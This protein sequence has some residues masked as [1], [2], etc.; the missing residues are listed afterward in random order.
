MVPTRAVRRS[1]LENRRARV[2]VKSGED[3][4][5]HENKPPPI[6][7]ASAFHVVAQVEEPSR[8]IDG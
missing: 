7:S 3:A 4:P 1:G 5:S 2:S 8:S 6:G